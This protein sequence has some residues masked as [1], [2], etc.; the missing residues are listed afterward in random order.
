M[1]NYNKFILMLCFLFVFSFQNV[2]SAISI[3]ELGTKTTYSSEEHR[4]F[5][6]DTITGQTIQKVYADPYYGTSIELL[7]SLV[8]RIYFRAEILEFRIFK[9]GGQAICSF[10][11][12]DSDVLYELPFQSNFLPYIFCGIGFQLFIGHQDALDAR[13]AFGHIYNL[14]A[15]IGLKYVVSKKIKLFTE[16]PF[17]TER[18]ILGNEDFENFTVQAYKISTLGIPKISIGLRI[19]LDMK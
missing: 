17:F 3:F 18:Y 7:M 10:P 19:S 16:C 5:Y 4:V 2:S 14:R 6:T 12:L 13:F 15:G 1:Q 11:Y 8:N 9:R